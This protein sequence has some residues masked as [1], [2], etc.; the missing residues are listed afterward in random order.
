MHYCGR[1]V[2][3][4]ST[5]VY[6]EDARGHYVKRAVVATTPTGLTG[7]VARFAESGLRVA[8]EA[9][10]Q[11]AGIIDLLCQLGAEVHVVHPLKVK[12]I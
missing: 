12:L 7:V 9:G 4:K 8:I 2:S 1:D 5:H 10:N 11:T 6:V 3:R